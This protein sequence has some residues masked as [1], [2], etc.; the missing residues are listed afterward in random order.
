[1]ALK[2][3]MFLHH[4]S[5]LIIFLAILP[6]SQPFDYKDALSKSILYFESQRSGHLPDNQRATWR[7]DSGLSDGLEQ[8]VDLIGG[9][10]DAG[11]NVKFGLP[12]AFTVTM[13]SWSVI[14]YG[15][16]I[17]S[18]GEYQHAL[19]AIKWGTDYFI[20]AHT[21]PNVLWAQV[22]SGFSDHMCWQRPEDMT[23]SRRAYKVDKKHPG[24]DLAGETAA[25]MAAASIVFKTTNPPYSR[26][27]LKHAE[28]LFKFADKYR[29]RYDYSLDVKHGYYP[30]FSG[31]LDELLWAAMWLYRATE[32]YHYF[33]Y[34]IEKAAIH[35]GTTWYSKEFT[36]DVKHPGLQ[37]LASTLKYTETHKTFKKYRSK[38]EIFI[39]ACLNKNKNET[40]NVHRTPGGLVWVRK[41]NNMN[42][43]VNAAFLLAVYSD[44]LQAT[45]QTI[46]CDGVI[47]GPYDLLNFS[48]SQLDY[49]LGSNPMGMSY[50]VGY[51]P[52][53]PTRVHHR[54]ASIVSYRKH[55]RS[56]ECT[57]GYEKWFKNKGPNPNVIVGALVG[58]P[59]K[60]DQ[61]RDERGHYRQTEACTYNTAPLVGILAK[62]YGMQEDI[63]TAN[64][65]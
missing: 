44:H 9:Y 41:W 34:A 38:G 46:D 12:M 37:I 52:K 14:E 1:M 32:N 8:G 56:I 48:K 43:V 50:L 11:D 36:W 49:I 30:S 54:G 19:E 13:L 45:N 23:T 10:Y 63:A 58:G 25:A 29:G 21:H 22:G 27:L 64:A 47:V 3:P 6:F 17:H 55:N 31:Y 39:C 51:G 33:N 2:L 18:A 26:L 62:F 59:D 7:Y 42:Y 35:G 15:G 28:Q 5:A 16:Q 53:Y 57:E 40:L 4:F 60:M 24:S 61:F 65:P 20:K